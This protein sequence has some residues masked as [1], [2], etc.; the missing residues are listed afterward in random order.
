MLNRVE[1]AVVHELQL[2]D[3]LG[4]ALHSQQRQ[5]FSLLL[6]LLSDDPAEQS[7]FHLQHEALPQAESDAALRARLEVGASAP[8]RPEPHSAD[9][10]Y[11]QACLCAAERSLTDARL[12][13]CLR[14]QPLSYK[15]DDRVLPDVT[16][17]LPLAKQLALKG[18]LERDYLLDDLAPALALAAKHA[19]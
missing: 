18:Q 10:A 16:D 6:K 9:D 17:Q 12:L 4:Q 7:Q 5:T 3:A 1:N 2:G 11:L 19:A 14:P 8:L 13:H 15:Q